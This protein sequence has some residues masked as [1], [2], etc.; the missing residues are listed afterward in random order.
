MGMVDNLIN[1][2]THEDEVPSRAELTKLSKEELINKCI[3]ISHYK[4][5]QEDLLLNI[6]HDLRSPLSVI[7]SVLQCYE[8]GYLDENNNS[9]MEQYT[10]NIKRNS[11]KM[12][13]LIDNL[14]DTTRLERDYY[15]IERRNLDV[16]SLIENTISSI[17]RY[18]KQ[19]NI[20]LIFD[21]NIEQCVIAVDAEALDR[22]IVNLIS[23]AIKFSFENSNIYVNLWKSS[24]DLI[25]SV[26]DEGIGIPIQDQSKIFDRFIQC[27]NKK[28]SEHCGSGIGLALVEHLTKAHGGSVELNSIENKGS[29]FI[30]KLPIIKI[31]ENVEDKKNLLSQKDNVQMLEIEFSDIYL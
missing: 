11:L 7:L 5:L 1:N 18:A 16:V 10:R 8:S 13:K 12:L 14:I 17:D 29:E 23:N 19:K 4:S 30:I 22:I 3:E 25:I 27:T 15:N 24:N 21:T 31:K 9:K 28:N 26:K 6:S 2:V 20:S